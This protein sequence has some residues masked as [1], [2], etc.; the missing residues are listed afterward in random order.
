MARRPRIHFPS[1][2][3]HVI[4]QGT[5]KQ[6]VFLNKGDYYS[7]P[8]SQRGRYYQRGYCQDRKS[9]SKG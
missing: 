9:N 1:A 5:Q 8:F 2:L 6:D 3:Y 4:A 7:L